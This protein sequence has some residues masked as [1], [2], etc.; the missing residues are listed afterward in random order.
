MF[1][2]TKHPVGDAVETVDEANSEENKTKPFDN[3]R[4]RLTWP[5]VF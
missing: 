1:L 2:M 5:I 4:D 3:V